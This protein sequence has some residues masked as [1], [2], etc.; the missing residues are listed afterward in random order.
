LPSKHERVRRR[1]GVQQFDPLVHHGPAA[2]SRAHRAAA[3]PGRG[4]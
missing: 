4:E 1:A 3:V 2:K